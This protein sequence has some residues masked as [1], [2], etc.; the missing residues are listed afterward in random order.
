MEGPVGLVPALRHPSEAV[1]VAGRLGLGREC[2][3]LGCASSGSSAGITCRSVTDQS[4]PCCGRGCLGRPRDIECGWRLAGG[5]AAPIARPRCLS[6]PTPPRWSARS[7]R[8]S[9]AVRQQH[10][11]VRSGWP[12]TPTP[13]RPSGASSDGHWCAW[14]PLSYLGVEGVVAGRFC[15]VLQATGAWSVGVDDGLLEQRRRRSPH[16]SPRHRLSLEVV[17]PPPCAARSATQV[18]AHETTSSPSLPPRR[19]PSWAR[20]VAGLCAVVQAPSVGD[21]GTGALT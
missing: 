15:R 14:W 8:P 3:G 1:P 20:R 13:R 5:L 21:P 16:R 19:G 7:G 2:C 9:L 11:A 12:S 10:T 17:L 4:P 6:R 18:S